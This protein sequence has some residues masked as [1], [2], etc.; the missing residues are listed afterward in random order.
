MQARCDLIG[1]ER[2]DKVALILSGG[3]LAADP[4]EPSRDLGGRLD[5]VRCGQSLEMRPQCCWRPWFSEVSACHG[6]PMTPHPGVVGTHK[7]QRSHLTG[8]DAT[9]LDSTIDAHSRSSTRV[10]MR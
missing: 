1:E 6:H 5:D 7:A 9:P 2:I 10:P 3:F 8:T 4:F